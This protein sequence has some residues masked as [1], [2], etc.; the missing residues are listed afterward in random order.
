MLCST[1]AYPSGTHAPPSSANAE[2]IYATNGTNTNKG[3]FLK[4]YLLIIIIDCF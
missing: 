4:I 2:I 1:T 3:L